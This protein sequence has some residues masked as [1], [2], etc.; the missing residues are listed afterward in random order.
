[1]TLISHILCG[2]LSNSDSVTCLVALTKDELM[3]KCGVSIFPGQLE[4]IGLRDIIFV[5]SVDTLRQHG[6]PAKVSKRLNN[7]LGRRRDFPQTGFVVSH[8]ARAEKHKWKTKEMVFWCSSLEECE[9]WTAKLNESVLNANPLRPRHLLVFVNPSAGHRR[10]VQTYEGIV[11][12][13]FGLAR[14][15]THVIV[16]THRG[17]VTEY[18]LENKLDDYDGVICVGGDGFLAEAV[19]GVLLRERINA[20]LPLHAEHRPGT[21]EV[22]SAMRLGVI[23]AGSTDT[24]VFS[25]QGTNDVLS[26]ILHIIIGDDLPLDVAAIHSGDDGSFV[27]YAMSLVG[28]GF[29]ADLLK[30]D[31]KLRWMGPKRYDCAGVMTFLAHSVYAGEIS[32]LPSANRISHSRDGVLCSSGCSVC[33]L[34]TNTG[35]SR[36]GLSAS[37][38]D[39]HPR[40]I[41]ALPSPSQAAL[42]T[43]GQPVRVR[44]KS[45][46]FYVEQDRLDLPDVSQSRARST[47]LLISGDRQHRSTNPS[48][49][50][51]SSSS[52]TSSEDSGFHHAPPSSQGLSPPSIFSSPSWSVQG[53]EN[54]WKT[55]T[56]QFIAIN[57]FLQSC[58]CMKAASG[59]SPWT[60]LGDGC[61]DLI[62]VNK[63][64]RKQ[65]LQFLV[66]TANISLQPSNDCGPQ[67]CSPFDLPFVRVE[68]VC[69]FEFKGV[70][71]LGQFPLSASCDSFSELNG[72]PGADDSY[73]SD[74]ASCGCSSNCCHRRRQRRRAGGPES[75]WCADGEVV[76]HTNVGVF[77]HRHLIRL[78]ARGPEP[79]CLDALDNPVLKEFSQSDQLFNLIASTFLLSTDHVK[80][81]AVSTTTFDS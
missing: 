49:L 55:F 18:L 47:Q 11:R 74:N 77:V 50:C 42:M 52:P 71:S 32:Y 43:A 61:L 35:W 16:T 57:A 28:Y 39:T 4:R 58:R 15:K 25:T 75:M 31:D 12:P 48:N 65:F 66:R 3:W 40:S 63:C 59:P 13:L 38:N 30:N 29:H 17:H 8:L 5:C 76:P 56:G 27:R 72:A 19:Q 21:A 37:T 81:P 6:L 9:K 34:S 51:L 60:H 79:L 70:S 73:I 36:S 45:V 68:R 33:S 24:V 22:P 78:F 41:G 20:N 80:Q 46:T 14:I 44:H 1:M 62:L 64:T 67:Q 10:A 26:S 54:G 2:F 69:A 7:L 53:C 23:P